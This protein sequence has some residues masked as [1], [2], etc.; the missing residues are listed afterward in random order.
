VL[1]VGSIV[2]ADN[3]YAD[4]LRP[5]M[6][7][8]NDERPYQG[9][10]YTF[11]VISRTERDKAV[12]LESPDLTEGGLDRYPSFVNPWSL[13]EVEHDDVR[14]RV[15][16]VTDDIFGQVADGIARFTAPK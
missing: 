10:Q 2:L 11:A 12:R 5:M 9:K 3:P 6:V 1:K 8:S 4:G 14:A 7:V 16:Q 13:H 15:G